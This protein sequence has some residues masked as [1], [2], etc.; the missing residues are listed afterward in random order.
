[1]EMSV[2][3]LQAKELSQPARERLVRICDSLRSLATDVQHLS[4]RL[5]SSVLDKVGLAA[6]LKTEGESFE[7]QT[8]VSVTVKVD[9]GP[10]LSKEAALCLYRIA[11]EALH[12]VAKHAQ[13]T[14]AEISLGPRQG[15]VVLRVSDD[16]V[17]F[18]PAESGPG[19]DLIS[20]KE[21]LRSHAGRL[22]V[23][24]R[25]EGGTEITARLPV[26]MGKGEE[27][28]DSAGR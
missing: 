19:L 8:G 5:H 24:A 14:S 9:E 10:K 2:L 22:E 23:Q 20:M 15:D 4:R 3:E 12:N 17:G 25:P 16:G 6:A 1:M 28:T 13:A 7:E 11:Q 27:T 26:G 18:N 21:R